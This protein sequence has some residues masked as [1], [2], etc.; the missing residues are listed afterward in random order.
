MESKYNSLKEWLDADKPAYMA[1]YRNGMIEEICQMMGWQNTLKFIWTKELCLEEALKYDTKAKWAKGSSPS[2][3]AA[4][5]NGWFK[6][7][8]QH[9]GKIFWTKELCIQDALKFVNRAEWNKKSGR[10]SYYAKKHGFLDECIHQTDEVYV[11]LK[12]TK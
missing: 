10:A 4:R 8:C 11:A 5:E 12:W 1:A 3:N 9:M 6:E 7:C 2:Y